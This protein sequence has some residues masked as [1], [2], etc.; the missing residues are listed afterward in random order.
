[1]VSKKGILYHHPKL[2]ASRFRADFLVG[3]R[4]NSVK[5]LDSSDSLELMWAVLG[6][7]RAH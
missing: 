3:R 4:W 7:F 5:Y 1:M 6:G 2:A